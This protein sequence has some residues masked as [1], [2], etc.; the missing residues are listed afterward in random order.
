MS[1]SSSAGLGLGAA[2]IVLALC[3]AG[4]P[5]S[6]QATALAP[7]F[8]NSIVSTHPDGRQARLWLNRDSTYS[9]QGRRGERSG[10]VWTLKGEKL[11]LTQK[12]PIPIPFSYCKA[13]PHV[14]VGSAWSDTAFNGD[15]VKNRLVAGR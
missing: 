6:A 11:C 3:G 9:A 14:D 8:G 12:R 13:F 7:A 4:D 5:A 1:G 10:G 15:K 2:L